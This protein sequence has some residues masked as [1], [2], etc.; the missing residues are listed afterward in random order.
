MIDV[1][2]IPVLKDNYTYLIHEPI[3]KKTAVIGPSEIQPILTILK[4][5]NWSLDYIW[6]THHHW[7]HTDGNIPLKEKTQASIIGSTKDKHRIPGIDRTVSDNSIFKFGATDVL[8]IETPG[9]TTGAIC[10][11]IKKEDLLFTGDTLFSMGCGRLFEGT[12]EQMWNSL[13]KLKVLPPQ[14]KIYCGHEYTLQNCNFARTLNPNSLYLEKKHQKIK[15]LRQNNYPTVPVTMEEELIC[16]PFLQA[17]TTE[18]KANF[19]LNQQPDW[20][21]FAALRRLKDQS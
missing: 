1:H 17:N 3:E 15:T 19:Q 14:T 6:N 18:L 20:K 13:C 4:K 9:H 2:I 7:D 8:I 11:W 21:T 12:A 16:N 5:N 10:W